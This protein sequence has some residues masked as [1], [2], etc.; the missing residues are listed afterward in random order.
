MESFESEM[1]GGGGDG[2]GG[3]NVLEGMLKRGRKRT[4]IA[5]KES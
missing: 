5:F 4:S 2:G 3:V 1:I